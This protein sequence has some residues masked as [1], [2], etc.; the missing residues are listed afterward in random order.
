MRPMTR[1]LTAALL[2]GCAVVAESR[3][4]SADAPPWE[5][6][7]R[8]GIVDQ[9]AE[10]ARSSAKAV[11]SRLESQSSRNRGDVVVLYLLARAYGK[12]ERRADAITA[13]G[14]ALAVES[15][16]WFAWRDRGV[17]RWLEKDVKGA[18]ADLRKAVEL[19]PRMIEA[20]QPL[21]ALLIEQKRYAEGIRTL[22]RVLDVDPGLDSA[23]L[24]IAEAFAAM[25]HPKEAGQ[26]LE[27]LLAKAPDDP[28]LLVIKA[29]FLAAQGETAQAQAICKQL[30]KRNPND[31]RPLQV[32]LEAAVRAKSLDPEEG[33]WILE[34]LLRLTRTKEA[35][36][37]IAAQIAGLRRKASEAAQPKAP[38]G[39]P[40]ADDVA[41]ALRAPDAKV[42]ES[43]MLYLV[44][45]VPEG[46]SIQGE[47]TLAIVERL[48]QGREPSAVVRVLALEILGRYGTPAFASVVRPSLR[49][50]D[51][52]VRRKAA[53]VLGR[54]KNP[55][56]I[57]ALWRYATGA[58]LDLAVSAR[59]AVYAL[60]NRAPP[61]ADEN[62]EAQA[63]AFKQWWES[64]DARECKLAAIAAVLTSD[65]RVLDELLFPLAWADADEVS[66]EAA[67]RGLAS[68]VELAKKS[69]AP[70]AKWMQTLPILGATDP[71][72]AATSGRPVASGKPF[73]NTALGAWWM[74]RP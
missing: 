11:W 27:P 15:G 14:E 18:E 2:V 35:H 36:D 48:D 74:R 63:A 58:D 62:S 13:Y 31:P 55:L 29:R 68:L 8:L 45:G 37:A 50:E 38:A 23:R 66:S 9:D 71:A 4:A 40:T 32:W 39:P 10:I 72:S 73:H 54:L 19:D 17:L 7:I 44:G 34:R 43:A 49:D 26:T 1:R 22:T 12:G 65:D 53:D 16:C 60:A 30:T 42:R 24:Q 69:E 6:P 33:I 64:V 28:N 21:G 67:Y 3:P 61:V 5:R 52:N 70:R 57:A 20:L 25:D 51:P 46:F 41:R 56:G 59:L 47:L